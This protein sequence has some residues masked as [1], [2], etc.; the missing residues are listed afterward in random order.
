MKHPFVIMIGMTLIA[1]IGFAI[2]CD[3]STKSTTATD[4]DGFRTLPAGYRNHDGSF[5]RARS[6][7]Y[8]WSSSKDNAGYAW[9]RYLDSGYNDLFRYN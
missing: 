3:R 7:S 9:C 8:F 6:G 4:T 5:A 2:A 1:T